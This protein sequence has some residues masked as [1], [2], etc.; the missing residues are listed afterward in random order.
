[1]RTEPVDFRRALHEVGTD[2]SETGEEMARVLGKL[3]DWSDVL[4]NKCSVLVGSA[5]SGKT[6]ELRLRA[7]LLRTDGK[8]A[9]FVSVREL[10]AGGVLDEA[11]ES[12]E[13]TAL[14]AWSSTPS[15]RLFLFVDSLDEA[16]LSGPRDV[17]TCLRRLVGRV[18][19]AAENVTWVVSTRPAVLNLEVLEAIDDALGVS[20]SRLVIAKHSRIDD[21]ADSKAVSTASPADRTVTAKLY[22]L[23]KFTEVQARDFLQRVVGVADA[24]AVVSAARQHGLGHLLL[25]PGKCRLLGRMRLLD[26]PPTSLDKIFRRSIMLHLDAPS[27]GRKATL[28]ATLAELEVEASRLAAASTLCERMNIELPSESDTPSPQALSARD[29]VR[30]LRDSEL[31]HLLSSDFFEESGHQQV[32]IQP[33]DTRF[34]LAARRLCDLIKGREDARKVAQVLGWRAPSGEVG[35]FIPFMPVAG[36]LATLS[37]RFRQECMELDVQ[38]VAFFGDLRCLPVPEAEAVL[39]AAVRQI[40]DGREIGRGAYQLTADNYWQAGGS[41]LMPCV[42]ALF[43]EYVD[44]EDVRAILLDIARTVRSSLLRGA[45]LARIGNRHD[46]VL[47]DHDLLAY[48]LVAGDD[49]DLAELRRAALASG[50]LSHG[51]LLL[52]IRHCAWSTLD[53]DDIM[54]LVGKALDADDRNVMLRIALIHEACPSAPTEDL[55]ALTARLLERLV[56]SLP[57][58]EDEYLPEDPEQSRWLAEV[59]A[60]ALAELVR[61]PVI[62]NT[63]QRVASLI[64]RFKSEVLDRETWQ[65]IDAGSLRKALE[66]DS[67]LR[68]EVVR[69]L[70]AAHGAAGEQEI[71]RRFA[72]WQPLIEVTAA[73]A[74]AEQAEAVAMVLD[75]RA[76]RIEQKGQ[77]AEQASTPVAPRVGGKARDELKDRQAAMAAGTDVTALSWVAQRLPVVGGT[78]RFGDVTLD[79]FEAN[80]GPEL[81]A[82]V[83]TGLKRL[84]RVEAPRRDEDNTHSTYWSTIAGLQGLYLE[85]GTGKLSQLTKHE[86]RRAL[87]YGLYELNGVPK[88]YWDLAAIDAGEAAAFLRETLKRAEVGAVSAERAAKVLN[89]L[90]DAPLAI[91]SALAADA[92]SAVCETSL[93]DYRTDNVLSVL[94][95]KKLVDADVFAREAQ[96]RVFGAPSGSA[97]ALWAAHWMLMDAAAFLQQM[98]LARSESGDGVDRMIVDIATGLE[99][100]R[101]PNIQ[102]LAKTSS[103]AVDA[104]KMLYREL[105]RILPRQQDESRPLDDDYP[106]QRESAQRTRDRL[107]GVL[108]SIGTTGGYLA[109]RELRDAAANLPERLYLASL[110]YRTAESMQRS[111]RP[112]TEAEYVEF[113]GSLRP[114]PSSLDA[115]AQ[116]VENDILDVKD[117]VEKGEFSPRRFLATAVQDVVAGV[118]KSMEDDFQ[119][120]LGGLLEVLGRK[121]YSVFRESQGSDDAR[122]DISIAMPA[123][124]WKATL[125]LKVTGGDWTVAEYRDSLRSQLVGLYMRERHTTVGYFVVLRQSRR[126]WELPDGKLEYEELLRLL[127]EDALLLEGERPELRLRVIGIDA[128]EP[129]KADGSPVRANS[130]PKAVKEAKK[131]KKTAGKRKGTSTA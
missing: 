3:Q 118:V 91:Q 116:Q 120:Y 73:E 69:Q 106:T 117:I 41:L 32:K 102:E 34:Y 35:I 51:S 7:S 112:M 10:L 16:A 83:L 89:L 105:V 107:P 21:A 71:W 130:E 98:D 27:S 113:E 93:D 18:A 114:P 54:V 57:P 79:T 127:S 88:W 47:E 38:C 95:G 119:L 63:A 70:L 8:H 124:G 86:L 66:P 60:D 30:G 68:S 65:R 5:N 59:L 20:V 37:H 74:R 84:W 39:K 33:D 61:R 40:A 92:W 123:E 62:G 2:W 99:H 23:S 121:Q 125:E 31:G 108:A 80:C 11:L 122:R 26:E 104:V 82:A 64:V 96:K 4:Q 87:D 17:R 49:A 101:G 44:H 36:W 100:G 103:A 110:M 75:E 72:F 90:G 14:K 13:A 1:M 126:G 19:V 43:N 129:L 6:S 29:V 42:E 76:E 78:S 45:A 115:F 58:V 48:L 53:V 111:Q 46:L 52:L 55:L 25:S 12:R 9:C 22:K 56:S 94:V 128:T 24:S 15:E 97:S 50:D 67:L 109:L 81:A 77:R 85:F 28:K 131:A